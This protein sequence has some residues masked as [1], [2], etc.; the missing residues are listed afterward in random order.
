MAELSV[1]SLVQQVGLPV[2]LVV[3]FVWQTWKREKALVRRIEGL[4]NGQR[5]MLVRMAAESSSAITEN[6]RAMKSQAEAL[7]K[8]TD[9]LLARPCMANS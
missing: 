5:D 4:E 9:R 1:T 3:F 7:T 8:F 6:A 2:A